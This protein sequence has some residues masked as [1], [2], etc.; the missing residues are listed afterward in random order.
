MDKIIGVVFPVP[1]ELV[2]RLLVEGR[3][4]FVKYLPRVTSVNIMPKSKLL[5]YASHASKK[6]VGEGVV[7]T[8]EFLAPNEVFAKYG[9]KVF[10]NKDELTEYTI[11]QPNRD[12][13]K[14]MLVLVLSKLRKYSEPKKFCGKISMVGQYLT[15]RQYREL[16]G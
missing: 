10:L 9:H 15:V 7:D 13:S 8:I 2:D 16:V 6:I 11:Q 3:N 14:K 5:F 4:I 12:C 1:Q